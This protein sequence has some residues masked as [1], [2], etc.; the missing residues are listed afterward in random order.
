MSSYLSN[1]FVSEI[2]DM[3]DKE[4]KTRKVRIPQEQINEAVKKYLAE[5]IGSDDTYDLIRKFAMDTIGITENGKMN[6]EFLEIVRREVA[7]LIAKEGIKEQH[8][9]NCKNEKY[10]VEY[11]KGVLAGIKYAIE[12]LNKKLV[13]FDL[14][15]SFDEKKN[16]FDVFIPEYKNDESKED[17]NLKYEEVDVEKFLNS[18]LNTLYKFK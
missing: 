6:P 2:M 4:F 7:N 12:S 8:T 10:G 15:A 16:S 3:I 13:D 9:C 18:L 11:D 1:K 14:L 17:K 5:S